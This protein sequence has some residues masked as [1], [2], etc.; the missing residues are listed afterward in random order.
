LNNV[1]RGD[2]LEL[3]LREDVHGYESIEAA[4]QTIRVEVVTWAEKEDRWE[5][6]GNLNEGDGPFDADAF[7][8]IYVN[9]EGPSSFTVS[10][11]IGDRGWE[12]TPVRD[13]RTVTNEIN[14][15]TA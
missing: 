7:F 1:S 12:P 5:V 4:D 11:Q 3:V 6:V 13:I 14:W 9:K 15:A 8:M 10:H 2:K